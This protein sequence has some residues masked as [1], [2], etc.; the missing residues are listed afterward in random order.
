M[1]QFLIDRIRRA[2]AFTTVFYYLKRKTNFKGVTHSDDVDTYLWLPKF[3]WRYY[4]NEKIIWDYGKI[5]ALSDADIKFKII[6]S[7][8]I[9]TIH[10]KTVHL[11]Y[12]DMYNWSL[13][14]SDY[15]K[16]LHDIVEQLETQ[17]NRVFPSSKEIFYWENKGY[18]H[19]K[20]KEHNISEPQTEIKLELSIS[21]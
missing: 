3:G 7:D 9:G 16:P 5:N 8:D 11:N 6:K 15:T 18:M 17:G 20:F 12:S 21:N 10:N 2:L 19:K 14:Y 13:G 1:K 4:I